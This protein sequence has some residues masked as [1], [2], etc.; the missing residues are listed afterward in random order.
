M[1]CSNKSARRSWR[2]SRL[3]VVGVREESGYQKGV[4]KF[5]EGNNL[6]GLEC[7][8]E[9]VPESNR[10]RQSVTLEVDAHGEVGTNLLGI[11]TLRC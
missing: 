2:V 4:V 8:L 6:M 5:I 9:C 11:V 10:C 7:P 3:D 1:F